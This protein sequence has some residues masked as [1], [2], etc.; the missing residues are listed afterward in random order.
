ML[1]DRTVLD[2]RTMLEDSQR[3]TAYRQAIEATCRGRVVAEIGTGLGPLALYALRAGATRVY[4][5][6]VDRRTLELARRL[7]LAHGFGV[8]Q[9]VPI[10]GRSDGINLPEP[11][12]VLLCELLDS[13]GVGENVTGYLHD[14]RRRWLRPGGLVIPQALEV[15]VALADSARFAG[16]RRFWTHDLPRSSG[17][18]FGPIAETL[19]APRLSWEVREEEILTAWHR[20]QDL[21]LASGDRAR[22]SS[23]LRLRAVRAGVAEGIAVAFRA[24]LASGV[25]IDTHPGGRATHWKQG[26]LPLPC[27][28]PVELG[29]VFRIELQLPPTREPWLPIQ[30]LL[31]LDSD[32]GLEPTAAGRRNS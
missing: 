27:P 29:Q 18:D 4:G 7:I 28:V 5:V 3:M 16:E 1:D 30:A 14:A 17:I 8:D 24:E 6:E 13:T 26:W 19:L 25:S 20:W 12:D 32:A 22:A 9:F 15:D 21:D 11:V 2:H 31:D 23:V 10:C